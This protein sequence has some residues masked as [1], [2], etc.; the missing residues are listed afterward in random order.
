[1]SLKATIEAAQHY[2]KP[3]HVDCVVYHSPCNDGSGAAIGA[4]V[5]RGDT[6][7]YEKLAY[8]KD[9]NEA[10]IAGKNVVVLDA[11]FKK[12][13]LLRLRTIANGAIAQ[14]GERLHG[15]QEVSGSIPL[16]STNRVWLNP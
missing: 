16:S 9:F 3:E 15:M 8:H 4:W 7:T 14:L 6:V 10:A 1:M 11:S 5:A 12:D 13:E 2:L